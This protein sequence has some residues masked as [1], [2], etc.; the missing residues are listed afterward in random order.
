M[1]EGVFGIM[2]ISSIETL[3]NTTLMVFFLE[4]K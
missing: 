4:G 2:N 1:F 3:Y